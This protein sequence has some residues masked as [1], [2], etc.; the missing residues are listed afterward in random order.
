MEVLQTSALPLGYVALSTEIISGNLARRTHA[1]R[2]NEG[3][4][5]KGS[6][7]RLSVRV[8]PRAR[9]NRLSEALD[10]SLEIWTTAPAAEGRANDAIIQLIARWKGLP[11]SK[12]EIVTGAHGRTKIV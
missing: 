9:Q 1:K 3:W 2:G 10:G 4:G 12:V 7:I 5:S 8:H 11:A 6:M